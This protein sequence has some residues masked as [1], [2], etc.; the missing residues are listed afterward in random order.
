M[1]L[2]AHLF[3]SAM[4]RVLSIGASSSSSVLSRSNCKRFPWYFHLVK[5]FILDNK[6]WICIDTKVGYIQIY[7]IGKSETLPCCN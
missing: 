1:S 5:Q 6:T 2:A 3:C 7:V 4:L